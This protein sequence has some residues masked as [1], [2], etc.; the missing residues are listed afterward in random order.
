MNEHEE[1]GNKAASPDENV[2]EYRK[3]T[4]KKLEVYE[5]TA[6]GGCSVIGSDEECNAT[7]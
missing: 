3:P 7:S 1:K 2:A 4:V 6:L 5:T